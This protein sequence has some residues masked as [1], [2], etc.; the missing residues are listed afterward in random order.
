VYRILLY[1]EGT[2]PPLWTSSSSDGPRQFLNTTMRSTLVT[3][4]V[5]SGLAIAQTGVVK[6]LAESCNASLPKVVCINQYASVMPYH[7]FRAVSNGTSQPTFG[8]TSV[9]NDTSFG[10]VSSADF[11]VFDRKRGLE[12]LGTNPSYEYVFHVDGAV[13]EA[14]V[15]VPAQNKLYLSQLAPPAGYLPQLVVDLNQNPPTLSEFLF[16]PPVYAPNGGTFHNGLVYWGASGGNSSIGG[17]EQRTGIRTLDPATNK[18]TTLLNNYFGGYFNTVD[19]LFVHSNGDVWFTD[20]RK[21]ALTSREN[22]PS[23]RPP[24]QNIPGS[25]NSPTRLPNSNP[26]PTAT[27]PPPAPSTSSKTRSPNP[28]ASQSHPTNAQSTSPI[29]APSPAP[30]PPPSARRAPPSTPRA[31][32]RSTPSTSAVTAH[33]SVTS[34]PYISRRSGCQM[35][36]R[37]R[38]MGILSQA[39]EKG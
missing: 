19:D 29:P 33:T 31:N 12:L 37:W 16:D 22:I 11:L 10:Q 28:T 7:F 36:S 15:Y 4:A 8:S 20:P 26:P 9:P 3:G 18:T 14:P 21:K 24:H 2:H 5:F 38:E 25:T 27:A 6:P 23:N 34:A 13:H 30:S 32:A 17:T 35:G 39:R 1:L